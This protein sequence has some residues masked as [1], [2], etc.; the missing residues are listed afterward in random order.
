MEDFNKNND[1]ID[2]ETILGF[3]KWRDDPEAKSKFKEIMK[4][5]PH[6]NYTEPEIIFLLQAFDLERQLFEYKVN[7][8]RIFKK[9]SD[10][11]QFLIMT[12]ANVSLGRRAL[13]RRLQR[14]QYLKQDVKQEETT[15]R[16]SIWNKQRN[17]R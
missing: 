4:D 11:T 13:L 14:T 17:T 8:K 10:F 6:G 1:Y 12:V 3:Q 7:G 2:T 5:I 9:S 16:G 15:S